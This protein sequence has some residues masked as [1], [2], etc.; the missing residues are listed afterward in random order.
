[1]ICFLF[2]FC[3]NWGL[4]AGKSVTGIF[5]FFCNCSQKLTVIWKY[6][7]IIQYFWEYHRK[8]ISSQ[9]YLKYNVWIYQYRIQC[10]F[11]FL[12]FMFFLLIMWQNFFDTVLEK[13]VFQLI[14]K[15]LFNIIMIFISFMGLL[16]SSY[17]IYF[18]I[19][20]YGNNQIIESD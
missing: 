18:S 13:W 6:S 12:Y 8:L 7:E 11:R 1:M 5:T 19:M 4:F 16:I 3:K 20:K 15:E 9:N 14:Y 2:F 10:V 17:E